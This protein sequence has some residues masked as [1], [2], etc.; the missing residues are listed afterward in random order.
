MYHHFFIGRYDISL[1]FSPNPLHNPLQSPRPQATQPPRRQ[2]SHLWVSQRFFVFSAL[3]N[4]FLLTSPF[5]KFSSVSSWPKN[6]TSL[7]KTIVRSASSRFAHA[8][9]RLGLLKPTAVIRWGGG[10]DL[11]G[12]HRTYDMLFAYPESS[13]LCVVL[14]WGFLTFK[15]DFLTSSGTECSWTSTGNIPTQAPGWNRVLV[16]I[17]SF[18]FTFQLWYFQNVPE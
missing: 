16:F 11:Y 15:H 12:C 17:H 1:Q 13:G 18:H 9:V 8:D 7:A 3:F 14:C 10:G 4:F 5:R 2:L 6:C